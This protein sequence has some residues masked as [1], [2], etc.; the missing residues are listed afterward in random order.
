MTEEQIERAVERATDRLDAR[1]MNGTLTQAEYD[2]AI[3]ELSDWADKAYSFRSYGRERVADH[4]D[5][6]DRDDLGESPDY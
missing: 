3:K 4:V 6:Y 2:A 1:L 5:G